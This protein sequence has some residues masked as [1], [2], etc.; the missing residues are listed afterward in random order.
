MELQNEIRLS[1]WFEHNA[2]WC[3]RSP[4]EI[5][6]FYFKWEDRDWYA[7]GECILSFDNIKPIPLTPE[8]LQKLGFKFSP[9]GISGADMWQGMPFW[10]HE[11]MT[12]RGSVSTAKGG[13]LCL[14]GYFNSHIEF[15]H[16]LQN[17]YYALTGTE[18]EVNL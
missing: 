12:L 2:N 3:Y 1:N 8:K 16:Q 9:C 14:A 11:S 17:L 4:A 18:L 5:K 13:V 6:P 10:T 15:V 7:L